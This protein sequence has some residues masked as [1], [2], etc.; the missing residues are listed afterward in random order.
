MH[1]CYNNKRHWLTVHIKYILVVLDRVWCPRSVA[2]TGR[3][4]K[5]TV[6]LAA[7]FIFTN[8]IT[9]KLTLF[10]LFSAE[11]LFTRYEPHRGL[12]R[13]LLHGHSFARGMCTWYF[14][15][16]NWTRGEEPRNDDTFYC[17]ANKTVKTSVLNARA[18][19]DS[20]Q[21]RFKLLPRRSTYFGPFDLRKAIESESTRLC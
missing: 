5:R 6:V 14:S 10:L 1:V 21:S 12:C 13:K 4:G 18:C 2:W 17:I 19:V 3:V 8:K 11:G 15:E 7:W 9:F 20:Q 16:R